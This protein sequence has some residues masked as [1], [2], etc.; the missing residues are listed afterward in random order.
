ME[1]NNI[2]PYFGLVKRVGNLF[3]SASSDPKEKRPPTIAE[4]ESP[5]R[6]SCVYWCSQSSWP[7][8]SAHLRSRPVGGR[9]L[10][11]VNK[12][13]QL[14]ELPGSD[15]NNYQKR[16]QVHT[17]WVRGECHRRCGWRGCG[18]RLQPP[19]LSSRVWG[20]ALNDRWY[21]DVRNCGAGG[22]LAPGRQSSECFL[23]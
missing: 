16:Q 18:G 4:R 2:N 7:I 20:W 6:G 11:K 19:L 14:P 13:P 15:T 8:Y 1:L 5:G 3:L 17:G 9:P 12:S 22:D 23:S 10:R 21:R